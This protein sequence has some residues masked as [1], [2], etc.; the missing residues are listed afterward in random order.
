MKNRG[1]FLHSGDINNVKDINDILEQ[2]DNVLET[3][4]DGWNLKLKSHVED[5][6]S[7]YNRDLG[8]GERKK[9]FVNALGAKTK[10]EKAFCSLISG[11]STNLAELFDDSSLKEIETPKIEFA[12]SSLEDKIDGIQ[13]SLEDRFAVIE[14][15]KRL[16]DWK[17][18]TAILGDSSS[19]A[20][21]RVNSYQM[22]HEQLVELK[23]L[24]KEYLDRKV[25]Q[26]VFVSPSIAN[27]YPSYIGHTK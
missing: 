3:F 26:D 4:L 12:S 6:K 16:Y 27:N 20:E 19:L 18:L 1:N 15:A 7:I 9:A 11:G 17:T 10:A 22:H 2:L 5:I 13:E 25:F 8:R 24:V 21:A 23:Y 14:A